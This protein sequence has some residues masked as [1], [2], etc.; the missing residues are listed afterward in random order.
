MKVVLLQNVKALGERGAV[1]EV[2]D[3]HARN[4]LFPNNLAELATEQSIAKA[5][6]LANQ[7]IVSAK[8]QDAKL[9][10]TKGKLKG[11]TLKFKEKTNEEGKLFGSIGKKEII[12]K[13]KS[14][15]V[16]AKEGDVDLAEAFKEV[17]KF[18]V[19]VLG[20]KTKIKITKE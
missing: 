16:T 2:A 6:K 17:G 9:G 4:F 5:E 1:K 8:N 14:Q 10:E 7:N 11:L 19:V 3:G 18:G 20:E 15:G 12:K 13:L